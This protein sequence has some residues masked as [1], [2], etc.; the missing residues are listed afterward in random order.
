MKEPVR[1]QQLVTLIVAVVLLAVGV[2]V[3]LGAYVRQLREGDAVTAMGTLG[4]GGAVWGLYIVMDGVFLGAGVAIMACACIARFSRDRDMEAV[5]RIAMPSALACFLAA[6]LSVLADQGRPWVAL[7]NLAYY[8]RP[9]SPLFA[10]FTGVGAI[11]L[12]G[13]LVHCV[14]AR[15][16]DLAE[17]AKR[18]SFWRPLQRLLAAGY[19][20]S[21]GERHRRQQVGFWMSLLMLPALAVPLAA[22]ATLF[23]VR[24]GRAPSLAFWEAIAFTL[25]SGVAGLALL[26]VA[27]GLVGW[28][29]GPK[30]GLRPHGFARLGRALLLVDVL[31]VL[32]V[33]MAEIAALRAEDA[34]VVACARALLGEPYGALFWSE[35]GLF[36]AAGMVL[37]ISAA[38]GT[39][40]PGVAIVASVLAV[41]AAFLHRYTSLLSWQ[42]HGLLLPY[43]SGRYAP[44][45]V[46]LAV[47]V[48]IVSLALLLLL[49]SV[50]LIPFAPALHDERSVPAV[51]ADRRRR[52]LTALWLVLGLG[53]AGVGLASSLRLG[54]ESFLDPPLPGSP[55]LFIAGLMVLVTTGAVYEMLPEPSGSNADAGGEPRA[56]RRR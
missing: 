2:A 56:P 3:G 10:T 18:P 12:F 26:V 45:H 25:S 43:P 29:A 50:R 6:A 36:L 51:T 37:W 34:T 17:Y 54:T 30:A 35:L 38:R 19:R 9:Q 48:G 4:A 1:G 7:V 8:A 39:L 55:A 53:L 40:R 27:A 23:T 24:P 15:R 33:V 28:L 46:E 13:S 52:W 16:A 41:P 22:L 49:P 11:C 14:L 42:T 47:E 44:S 31:A 21:D 5:A 20:G 32:S